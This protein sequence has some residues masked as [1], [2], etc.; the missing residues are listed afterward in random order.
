M[1]DRDKDIEILAPRHQIAVLE[2]QLGGKKV[3]FTAPD[4][5]IL[6]A[7][8]Q[9]A[10]PAQHRVRTHHQPQPMRHLDRHPMQQRRQERPIAR[11]EP[12][13]VAAELA[14]QHRDL[15]TQREDLRI[16]VPIAHR[17]Q[18]QHRERVRHSQVSQSQQHDR[19]SSRA[20]ISL[21]GVKTRP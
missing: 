10:V 2:R 17:Q 21:K 5:A 9:I 6:P 12:H 11:G 3:R 15:M 16:L 4:R 8:D 14:L 20:T 19:P 13:S 7:C 1:G 18:T